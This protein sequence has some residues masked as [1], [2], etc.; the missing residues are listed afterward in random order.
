MRLFFIC[1]FVVIS[2]CK[3]ERHFANISKKLDMVICLLAQKGE[4]K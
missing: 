2:S 3:C 4:L 1:F